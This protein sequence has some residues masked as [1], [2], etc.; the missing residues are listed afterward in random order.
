MNPQDPDER[1]RTLY[2]EASRLE[3]NKMLAMFDFPDP[4][5]HADERVQTTT[6]LQKMF[7]LN[8]PFMVRQAEGLA[9]RLLSEVPAGDDCQSERIDRAYR[10]LYGREPADAERKLGLAFVGSDA[11][12]I[13]RWREYAH[14]LLASNEML[15]VD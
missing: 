2:S 5:I 1:R 6:P 12:S 8:S 15:F 10:L 3:L 13:G 11:E 4:N 7:V 14:V 9:E